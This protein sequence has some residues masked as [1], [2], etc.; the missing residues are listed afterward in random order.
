MSSWS[1]RRRTLYAIVV[2]V[3]VVG[4]IIIPAF[5]IFYR[6]PTCVDG[7]QN[8]SEQGVDCGG[9]CQRLCQSSFLPPSLAWT[10]FEEVAPSLYSI[11][12]YIVNPNTEGE[13]FDV[14]YRMTLF[15]DRG[16]PITDTEGV[17]TLPPHRNTLAFQGAVSVGKRIPSKALFE[18]IIAPD[19]HKGSDPLVHL[20]VGEKKYVEDETGSSLTVALK[21]DSVQPLQ[22]ITVYAVLYDAD[23]NALGF[24]KTIVDE[25]GPQGSAI[26]PFTWPL[27]RGGKVISIEVLPVVEK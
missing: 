13:A 22:Q 10:R 25:I 5:L 8:G 9:S 2:V 15:D 17:M 16:V 14:P 7:K 12:A 27:N 20:L 19:W 4:V 23:G 6:A 21:N 3:V 24:S 11:A 18:F 1:K 26:A